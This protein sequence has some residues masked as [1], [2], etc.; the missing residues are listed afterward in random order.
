VLV[1]ARQTWRRLQT[2]CAQAHAWVAL[3]KLCLASEALAKRCVPLLVQELR[4]AA[5]PAVR[6]NIMVA[7]ADLCIQ[8]IFRCLSA[9]YLRLHCSSRMNACCT[10]RCSGMRLPCC[11]SLMLCYCLHY[12][13]LRPAPRL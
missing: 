3:G 10:S 6:N 12:C 11:I 1:Q 5:V 2:H 13:K 7:L 9:V 4:A 8:V